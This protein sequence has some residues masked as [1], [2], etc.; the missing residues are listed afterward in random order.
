MIIEKLLKVALLG[1]TWVMYLMIALSVVSISAMVERWAFFFRRRMDSEDLQEGLL[2]QLKSGDRAGAK[3]FLENSQKRSLEAEALLPALEYLDS[4]VDAVVDAID[5]KLIK[6][7]QDM[8]RGSVL[9]GTLGNNAPFVGL[10]GTVI[11]VIIAF[12]Q[13]GNSQAASAMSNVMG[14]IAEALVSTGV[15]LFVAL[16]AVVAYNIIQKKINDVE[17][18]VQSITKH[19][20]AF[21]KSDGLSLATVGLTGKQ[22]DSLPEESEDVA[23]PSM[24]RPIASG[25]H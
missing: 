9:L 21:L 14:G 15:G 22:R 4:G 16:P 11:G 20:S 6:L 1:S 10:L 23:H 18:N 19:L 24:L 25:E 5:G 12:Q 17:S 13:L 7:R 8:E 2:K 3:K